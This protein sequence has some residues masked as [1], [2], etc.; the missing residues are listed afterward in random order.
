MDIF[1]IMFQYNIY[2]NVFSIIK[3]KNYK[4][5]LTDLV[6]NNKLYKKNTLLFWLIK[7]FFIYIYINRDKYILSIFI[8]N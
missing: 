6:V 7:K 5:I 8:I 3:N 2:K 4:I 1:I